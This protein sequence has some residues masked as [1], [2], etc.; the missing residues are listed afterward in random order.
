VDIGSLKR[1]ESRAYTKD[2]QLSAIL[3]N[4]P[5]LVSIMDLGGRYILADDSF[6]QTV[7][8]EPL[9]LTPRELFP[10]ATAGAILAHKD[11]AVAEDKCVEGEI[12][13][14]GAAG[15]PPH[16]YLA[17]MFPLR[18]EDGRITSVGGIM[19][20]VT[21]LK[22]A[23]RKALGAVTQRD[24]F[25]AVLSHE[26]RN[27]LAAVLNAAGALRRGP[28]LPAGEREWLQ[29]IEWRGRHM[30]RLLDDLLDL[31]RVTQNK[32]EIR[33]QVLDLGSTI[34]EAVE[35]VR[36]R[37]QEQGLRLELS[38]PDGPLP[39]EGEP[40][41]LQ[42]IHVNLLMNAA[43]Y[44]PGKDRPGGGRVWFGVRREG[45]RA[46]IRV[47]DN[48]IGIPAES[49]ENIF[50]LFVQGDH[51]ADDAGGGIGVGLTLVRAIVELHGGRIKAYSDGPG[52]GSEFVV[53]LPLARVAAG[54][55]A[56]RWRGGEDRHDPTTTPPPHHPDG[57]DKVKGLRILL[58]EDDADI[59]GT[60]QQVLEFDGCEVREA[61]DGPQALQA[62][63]GG[64]FDAALVD[65]GLPGMD[66]YELAR[67][68]RQRFDAARLPLV[69][70]TGYGR[71]SDRQAAR[72]AGFDAHLTKPV[73]PDELYRVLRSLSRQRGAATP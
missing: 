35:E 16:T 14:Q 57:P 27:P 41:R 9:G 36:A 73:D 53:W 69:A 33:K 15:G 26:L 49:L 2:E 37:F 55:E 50:D 56:A 58:V 29:V 66:G 64:A 12:V 65:I 61:G 62:V 67:R 63:E 13:I 54:G 45:D 5:N 48:G 70:L 4:S 43:K 28:G 44:T 32:I 30:A 23:E 24:R 10:L 52:T 6:R 68:L 8:R 7:G 72:E 1:A 22:E 18:D 11:R 34:D 46:V 31:A 59:R 47:R 38:R 40:A 3:R 51:A 42:Q 21:R 20:D 39:V 19:T 71:S 17:V 60:M 25:L